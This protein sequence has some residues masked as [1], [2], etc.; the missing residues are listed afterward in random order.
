MGTVTVLQVKQALGHLSQVVFVQKFTVIVFLTQASQPM[1]A[2]NLVV[3]HGWNVLVRAE[4]SIGAR[5]R[6]TGFVELAYWSIRIK[7]KAVFFAKKVFEFEFLVAGVG[8]D[9]WI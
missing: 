3:V 7:A 8:V 6:I 4:W 1:L 5:I 2:N 9:H